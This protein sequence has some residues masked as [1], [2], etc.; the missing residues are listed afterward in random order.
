M[1]EVC[2]LG[3]IALLR[4]LVYFGY[5]KTTVFIVTVGI[6][7]VY[8]LLSFEH[9]TFVQLQATTMHIGVVFTSLTLGWRWGL[10]TFV[11][12]VGVYLFLYAST[13]QGW[14]HQHE[15]FQPLPQLLTA[16]FSLLTV[17]VV[18][19]LVRHYLIVKSTSLAE[20]RDEARRRLENSNM[21]LEA[22]LAE[23]THKLDVTVNETAKVLIKSDKLVSLSQM[24]TG[25]S[26]ELGTPMGNALTMSTNMTDW[27]HSIR[28]TAAEGALTTEQLVATANRMS[29]ACDLITRNL[30]QANKLVRTFK[31]MSADQVGNRRTTLV[32]AKCVNECLYLLRPQLQ[33]SEVDAEV[34]IDTAIMMNTFPGSLEQIITNLIT[35][36]IVHGLEGNENKKL[37]ISAKLDISGEHVIIE[38]ADNGKGISDSDLGLIYEPFF[39][40]RRGKGGV[41]IG[42]SIVHNLVTGAL[43]GTIEVKTSEEGTSFFLNLPVDTPTPA[44][45][46]EEITLP[47]YL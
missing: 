1:S 46:T 39:T 27:A 38:V 41:G 19:L 44:W 43:H 42:L 2:L 36:A 6:A 37:R 25:I 4:V 14:I 9:K 7:A 45:G 15:V 21:R 31:Q 13:V 23:K 5:I 11:S 30:E 24:V 17:F 18:S 22:L 3:A 40:T 12:Y 35:N 33:E 26:H 29:S 10:A 8:V 34:Q 28:Q 20:E 47:A 16:L 32:L